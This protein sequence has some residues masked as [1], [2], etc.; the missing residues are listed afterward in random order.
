MNTAVLILN[1]NGS[2]YLK[3]FLPKIKCFSSEALVYVIDNGSSD[4]SIAY[5]KKDHP[6]VN[7]IA[8]V[9]NLGFAQGYHKAIEQISAEVLCLINS[10]VDVTERWLEKIGSFFQNDDKLAVLQPKVLDYS[11]KQRFEYAGAAGGFIDNWG[12]PYCRGR[13]FHQT[14]VD[15]GQYDEASEIFWASGACFFIRKSAYKEVGGFDGEFF[16]HMEE[17]DL[18]WR[19]RNKG[20][21]IAYT[22]ESKVYHLGAATL[23]KENPQK[24]FLNF[25]NNL[26]MLLKNLPDEHLY[27]VLAVRLF[28]DGCAGVYFLFQNNYKHTW[29]IARAYFFFYK[30]FFRNCKNRSGQNSLVYYRHRNIFFQFFI[31]GRKHFYKLR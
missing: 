12:Y 15:R 21:K 24:T 27:K 26:L 9:Q 20:Y 4:D 11:N 18:C 17:I 19:L 31:I 8:H 30:K 10:D 29:A 1:Y 3:Q 2:R 16:A 25:R 23:K 14:E 5:L 7:I 13:I 22:S 6:D 28:L